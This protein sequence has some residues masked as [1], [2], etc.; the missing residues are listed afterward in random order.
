MPSSG[1]P[2]VTPPGVKTSATSTSTLTTTGLPDDASNIEAFVASATP[3]FVARRRRAEDTSSSSSSSSSSYALKDLWTSF[4]EPSA[5]GAEVPLRLQEG[6]DVSQYYVPFLSGMQ[7]FTRGAEDG[8]DD[9][10]EDDQRTAAGTGR[11]RP[12]GTRLIFEFFEK[13][14]PYTRASLSDT[15]RAIMEEQPELAE[16]TSDD[17]APSSWMSVAWY[18]IYRIPQGTMLHDV[19]GCFLTYHALYVG[20]LRDGDI[21]C[22]LPPKMSN[23]V[24]RMIDE[25]V[26]KTREDANFGVFDGGDVT[27]AEKNAS[28]TVRV[29]RPFGLSMYKMQGD[30]WAANE[31]TTEWMN[32]L[33]DGAYTWLRMRKTVHPDYEF[34]SHFG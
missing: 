3:V 23:L 25:R 10:K 15:I 28:F 18:P 14:S 26:T 19:Q 9:A 33:M 29:L 24:E 31:T 11:V 30:V 2:P 17:L 8:E 6:L 16:M 34:F 1:E 27:D 20:E 7:L 22:P 12:G 5:F 13:A 32:K 4:V 21:A